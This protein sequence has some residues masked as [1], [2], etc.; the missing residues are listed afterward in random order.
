MRINHQHFILS[1]LFFLILP[2]FPLLIDGIYNNGIIR[3][4]SLTLAASIFTIT[5]GVSSKEP[6]VFGLTLIIGIFLVAIYGTIPKDAMVSFKPSLEIFTIRPQTLIIFA[7]IIAQSCERYTIHILNNQPFF[8]F[9]K[10][11]K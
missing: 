4:R 2:L 6:L 3:E 11:D 7:V 9:N 5:K 8:E 1:I 10:E